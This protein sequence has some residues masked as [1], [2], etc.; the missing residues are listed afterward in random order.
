MRTP[1]PGSPGSPHASVS[2]CQATEEQVE[3]TRGLEKPSVKNG[4]NQ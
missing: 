4:Y 1:S 2:K 3:S